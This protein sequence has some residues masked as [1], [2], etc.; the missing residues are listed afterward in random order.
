MWSV[1]GREGAHSAWGCLQGEGAWGACRVRGTRGVP[2]GH[3]APTV[4]QRPVVFGIA[5]LRGVACS[6]VGCLLCMGHPH[7]SPSTPSPGLRAS[8]GL[9]AMP[10]GFVHDRTT[11]QSPAGAQRGAKQQDSIPPTGSAARCVSPAAHG[12]TLPTRHPT[13]WLGGQLGGPILPPPPIAAGPGRPAPLRSAVM[14]RH[15]ARR[16]LYSLHVRLKGRVPTA[17]LRGSPGVPVAAARAGGR[18]GAAQRQT[19]CFINK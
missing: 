8:T 1:C 18:G 17:P 14:A 6:A 10:L 9:L 12:P 4:R 16:P 5:V 7:G 15:A 13:P 3:G 19:W 2:T 11:A